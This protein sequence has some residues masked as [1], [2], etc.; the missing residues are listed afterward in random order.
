M[1]AGHLHLATVA[2]AAQQTTSYK[3][4]PRK[5]AENTTITNTVVVST[6]TTKANATNNSAQAS[7]AWI[8]SCRRPTP[9]TRWLSAR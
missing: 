7:A 4:R 2:A 9:S 5:N 3:L 6:S 8:S 1:G